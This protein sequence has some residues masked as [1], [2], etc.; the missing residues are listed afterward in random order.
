M[1][2]IDGYI[3]SNGLSQYWNDN[4]NS[5]MIMIFT[6]N[7]I[8]NHCPFSPGEARSGSPQAA[9]LMQEGKPQLFAKQLVFLDVC[10]KSIEIRVQRIY[11][12][13][14]MND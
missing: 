9:D 6:W 7:P 4:D 5:D 12:N 3:V 8:Q 2:P 1:N 10:R 14:I 13:N 11:K